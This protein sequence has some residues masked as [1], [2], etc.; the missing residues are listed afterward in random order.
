MF[1]NILGTFGENFR[2]LWLIGI[3]TTR[4]RPQVTH[5][6]YSPSPPHSHLVAAVFRTRWSHEAI[7]IIKFSLFF[8]KDTEMVYTE[9]IFDLNNLPINF[10]EKREVTPQKGRIIF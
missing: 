7:V 9:D 10:G 4:V 8:N 5:V 1:R 2:P 6:R 3:T